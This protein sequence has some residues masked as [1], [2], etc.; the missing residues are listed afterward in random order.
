MP[1]LAALAALTPTV[2][3]AAAGGVSVNPSSP[4]PGTEVVLRVDGCPG[5]TATASSTAFVADARPTGVDGTL[6]G[7]SRIRSAAR[8]GTYAVTVACGTLRLTGTVTVVAPGAAASRSS[9][10]ASPAAPVD[11]GG[12]GTAPLDAA[13]ARPAGPGRAQAVTG[14]VLAG[15]AAVV[16]VVR[17]WRRRRGT[18]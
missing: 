13:G 12:G 6:V 18:D 4:A 16:V 5:R 10:P 7:E 2:A 3:H 1:A 8:P 9:A 14:L 11:A 17:G 15:V